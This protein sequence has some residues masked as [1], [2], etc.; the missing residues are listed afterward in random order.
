MMRHPAKRQWLRKIVR[1]LQ[2]LEVLMQ[3]QR[4]ML[5]LKFL[6][7]LLA[8]LVNSWLGILV[9]LCILTW[10]VFNYR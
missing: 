2:S 1:L 3:H 6:V 9:D 8:S 10:E 7:P 4:L 5:V